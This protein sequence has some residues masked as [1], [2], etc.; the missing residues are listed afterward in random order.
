MFGQAE[1]SSLL[2][3]E[4][5]FGKGDKVAIVDPKNCRVALLAGGTSGEREISINSGKGAQGALKE[6]GFEVEWID[7]ANKA[8]LK[9]LIE[10]EFDVAFLCLHGKMGEDGTI[11]GMLELLG[12]PY[13]CSGVQASAIAMDKDKSKILYQ[14]AGLKTPMSCTL[15]QGVP[16]DCNVIA[17]EV[18]LPCVVKPATE[19]SSL[20]FHV[21]HE[22]AELEK[23]IEETFAVDPLILVE[24]FVQ[25]REATVAIIGND[26][27]EALPV[28]EIVPLSGK[29]YDFE[30]KYANGGSKHICPAPFNEQL[31]ARL[32]ECAKTAHKALGCR[33]ASRTDFLIDEDEELWILETNTIPGMTATSLL[34]DA[35]HAAGISFPELCKKLIECALD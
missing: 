29:Y 28:I 9:R 5:Y 22:K 11:Q 6:A 20:G 18:G 15:K 17:E 25:G 30:A 35:A 23:A 4:R 19:G 3:D 27:V 2:I 12:I 16:Y 33:G 26:E 31:T 1:R 34:P 32:Q 24:R 13:T 10:E 21:V 7:P 8:D 14:H